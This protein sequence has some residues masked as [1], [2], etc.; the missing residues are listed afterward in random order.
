MKSLITISL[1]ASLALLA[2]GC[3]NRASSTPSS[4]AAQPIAQTSPPLA[5]AEPEVQSPA[6]KVETI[7]NQPSVSIDNV[8]LEEGMPYAD[9]RQILID[10][11][12]LPNVLGNADRND[13]RVKAIY[14]HGYE[15]IMAC[16]GTGV[17]ACLFEFTNQSGDILGV[18]ATP[19]SQVKGAPR[20]AGGVGG[21]VWRWSIRPQAAPP[22]PASSKS[23]NTSSIVGS[24]QD[25]SWEEQGKASTGE[26]VLLSLD[27]IQVTMRSLGQA[28][29][30]SYFFR[31]KIGD[32]LVYGVTACDGAF[33]TSED[34]DRYGDSIR[35]QSE[36]IRNMLDRLCGY[37]VRSA[38]VISP[39]SNV[40][41][42]PQGEVICTI[43]EARQ[44]TTYGQDGEWFYTDACEKLGMIHKSQIR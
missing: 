41:M 24:R 40:R 11:G 27:S 43:P 4:G 37:H 21:F 9:A 20:D 32:D 16:S 42:G 5:P 31:Y 22:S 10:Q 15:E 18:S 6:E 28:K 30:P 35:P 36:A 1:V 14:D 7:A 23:K 29:P 34:G 12:W 13:P 26:L 3:G 2:N 17:G 19:Y 38:Q 39:P 33:S 25:R 44:I 8:K